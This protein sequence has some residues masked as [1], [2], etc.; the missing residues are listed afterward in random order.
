MVGGR[1][2][3]RQDRRSGLSGGCPGDGGGGD[4]VS[5]IVASFLRVPMTA[6]KCLPNLV[7]GIP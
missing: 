2:P 1:P 5:R 6:I 4:P 3:P 7:S